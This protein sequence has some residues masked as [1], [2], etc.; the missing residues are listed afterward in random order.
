MKSIQQKLDLKEEKIL[1][2]V[3]TKNIHLMIP[4]KQQQQQATATASSTFHAVIRRNQGKM[5][6]TFLQCPAI[7]F[8]MQ[9]YYC[10]CMV[11]CNIGKC[12]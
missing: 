4:R 9:T 10:D 11:I 2:N 1:P 7:I 6:R 5:F 12:V 3:E 8:L